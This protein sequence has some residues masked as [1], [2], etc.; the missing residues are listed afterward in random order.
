MF[1]CTNHVNVSLCVIQIKFNQKTE[2]YCQ[3]AKDALRLMKACGNPH[4]H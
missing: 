1:K 2:F 4:E 3:I